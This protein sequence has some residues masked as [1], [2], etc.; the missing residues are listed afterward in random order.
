MIYI[1]DFCHDQFALKSLKQLCSTCGDPINIDT[2][3]T[4]VSV[5]HITN[6]IRQ[7][8]ETWAWPIYT[9]DHC[10]VGRTNGRLIGLLRQDIIKIKPKALIIGGVK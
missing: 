8:L 4:Y 2:Y 1:C 3:I 5:E 6:K 9:S 7:I 10:F